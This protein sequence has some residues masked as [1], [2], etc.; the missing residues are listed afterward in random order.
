[1]PD[2]P[3]RCADVTFDMADSHFGEA[4]NNVKFGDLV[5]QPKGGEGHVISATRMHQEGWEQPW[6]VPVCECGDVD[7]LDHHVVVLARA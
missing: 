3:G 2:H 5:W 4:P 1:M 6:S 7:M